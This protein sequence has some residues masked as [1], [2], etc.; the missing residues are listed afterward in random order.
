MKWLH[1]SLLNG[2][3]FWCLP[4]EP[5]Q[6]LGADSL[7]ILLGVEVQLRKITGHNAKKNKNFLSC[8]S[9]KTFLLC[10]VLPRN[11]YKLFE[12][13]YK[14]WFILSLVNSNMVV[15]EARAKA[16]LYKQWKGQSR[17]KVFRVCKEDEDCAG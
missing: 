17:T 15:E 10:S 11:I 6:I 8:E 3:T 13:E 14:E 7:K 16:H 4:L 2:I 9:C 5:L 12:N 1:L